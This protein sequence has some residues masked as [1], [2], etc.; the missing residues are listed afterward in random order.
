MD[1]FP[2]VTS[3]IG[4]PW[5]VA[6]NHKRE[7]NDHRDTHTSIKY[8]SSHYSIRKMFQSV[9]FNSQLEG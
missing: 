1:P 2:C 8:A 3:W 7:S 6:K 4:H 5:K 9:S